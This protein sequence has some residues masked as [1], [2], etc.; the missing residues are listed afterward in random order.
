VPQEQDRQALDGLAEP[1]V[2]VNDAAEVPIVCLEERLLL[3]LQQ[4]EPLR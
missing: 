3:V 4:V 2:V 1:E